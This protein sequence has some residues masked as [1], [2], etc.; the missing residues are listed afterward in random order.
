MADRE[1][2]D[3][4]EFDDHIPVDRVRA[5]FDELEDSA[6]PLDAGTVAEHADMARRTAHNKLN[7]LVDEGELRTKKV[8]A[9]G[10]IW[11][12]PHRE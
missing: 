6:E 8:G 10:R 3:T 4:G 9:R 12:I 2:S 5:V 11:W 7:D 1:R